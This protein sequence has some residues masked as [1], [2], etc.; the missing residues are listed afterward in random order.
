[1]ISIKRASEIALDR[2]EIRGRT[3][4][5]FEAT[6][7]ATG[8]AYPLAAASEWPAATRSR[9]MSSSVGSPINL[10]SQKLIAAFQAIECPPIRMATT[11]NEIRTITIESVG[12]IGRSSWTNVSDQ[13]TASARRG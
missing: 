8:A 9:T 3:C 10:A 2:G 12:A 11:D 5:Y 4:E 1:M 13:A 7:A 6:A